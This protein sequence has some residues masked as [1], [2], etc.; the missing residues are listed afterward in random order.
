MNHISATAHTSVLAVDKGI[1]LKPFFKC[2]HY[3]DFSCLSDLD[4]KLEC[5]VI[6]ASRAQSR[7][8]ID[9]CYCFF[10]FNAE[11]QPLLSMWHKFV[12]ETQF[13]IMA[14]HFHMHY[15]FFIS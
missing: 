9:L 3:L 15:F 2:C 7:A 11:V 4:G 8:V 12:R 6:Q 13:S 5:C 1:H 14:A 10:V